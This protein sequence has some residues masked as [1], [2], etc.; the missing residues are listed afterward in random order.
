MKRA[1]VGDVYA[2]KTERG[3]RIIQWG[4]SIEKHGSF[5][6]V[7]PDFYK[8]IPSDIEA[9]VSKECSYIIS[10]AIS[11][12]HRKN[13]LEFLYRAPI[14]S[15]SPFPKY[16]ISYHSYGIDGCFEVCEFERH[17]NFETFEGYPDGRGLPE[18]YK[19][20]N[21]INGCVDPVW[22]IY[23]LTSDFDMQHWD[24]FYPGKKLYDV[25]LNKYREQLF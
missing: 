17:Q 13:M 1:Q 7:F 16:D 2:F 3:Y 14:D 21:L 11:K 5:V 23:L 10:F 24:L 22:F 25:Y 8:E 20:V 4:Y 18:K 6:L 9:V 19:N 15:I 12:F